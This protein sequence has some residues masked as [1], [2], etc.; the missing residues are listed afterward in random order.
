MLLCE[1]HVA[2]VGLNF[3]IEMRYILL[4]KNIFSKFCSKK[5]ISYYVLNFFELRFYKPKNFFNPHILI[6][7]SQFY[8][9]QN[10]FFELQNL[11]KT[12]NTK[13]IMSQIFP[14]TPSNLCFSHTE[15]I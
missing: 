9:A 10:L 4:G 6:Q 15:V 1:L 13:I 11:H 3:A 8:I 5:Y 7:K 12:L 2:V 14:L